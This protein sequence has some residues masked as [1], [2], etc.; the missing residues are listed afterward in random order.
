MIEW[1]IL[2]L[3]V[4]GLVIFFNWLNG[5]NKTD[6]EKPK[7]KNN[8]PLDT[9]DEWMRLR[10]QLDD[11]SSDVKTGV[12]VDKVPGERQAQR[13]EIHHFHHVRVTHDWSENNRSP[14]ANKDHSERVWNKLGYEVKSGETYAYKYFGNEIFKPHQVQ[15]IGRYRN[16]IASPGLSE[17]QLKV[18]TIGLALVEK[19]G[20][21]SE[22]KDILLEQYGFDEETAKYAVGYKGYRDF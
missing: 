5:S 13:Q 15:K 3:I 18:K 12:L 4:W 1:V 19:T 10:Q 2:A 20:S 21:K 17:N 7:S 8:L 6:S 11:K 22:A 14:E 9:T 16:R